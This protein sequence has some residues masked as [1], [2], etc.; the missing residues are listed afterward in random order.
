MSGEIMAWVTTGLTVL[1]LVVVW[2]RTRPASAGE[3]AA[4]IREVTEY[5]QAAVMAAEQLWQTG[6]LPKDA[7]LDYVL[8]E[9]Q[10]QFGV[11]KETARLSAEAAVYWL[12]H[13]AERTRQPG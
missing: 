4:Q 5:A 11:D 3:A 9:L 8:D 13:V 10:K 1:L 12:K 6:K 2:V 7:R